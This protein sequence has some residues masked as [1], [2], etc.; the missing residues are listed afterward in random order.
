MK[1]VVI[2]QKDIFF[3]PKNIK[4]LIEQDGINLESVF[5]I[6]S[7]GSISNKKIY[8][9]KGFG[10]FQS[11]NYLVKVLFKNIENLISY[12]FFKKNTLYQI[13]KNE[14][15]NYKT[16]KDPNN[17]EFLN[18]IEQ[19]NID[20]VV[21]F[22]APVVFKDKLLKMP[23]YG[24]INLHCSYLPNYAGLMPS[25]WVMFFKEKFTGVTVHKMDSKID[26]GDILN[27]KKINI[28]NVNSIFEVIKLTKE[29][30]GNL[31]VETI[32]ALKN[33]NVISIKN[34]HDSEKYYSWPTIKQMK[35]F[36]KD[37]GKFI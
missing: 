24:C 19:S 16:I 37:G 34:K 28:Q 8:F 31:M 30:G 13:C 17:S 2:T 6:D 3:I 23:K 15:I 9:F 33:N 4:K 18:K 26:N 32:L 11:L 1:I 5:I 21:S 20:L 22:S 29:I 10:F 27:Q 25:F 7:K 14:R 12:L 36:I 35:K